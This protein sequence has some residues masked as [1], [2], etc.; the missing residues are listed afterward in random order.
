M[1]DGPNIAPES[2]SLWW[3]RRARVVGG[4][5]GVGDGGG[6]AGVAEDRTEAETSAKERP[7]DGEK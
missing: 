1:A 5:S 6:D 2:D 7:G 3:R 4:E